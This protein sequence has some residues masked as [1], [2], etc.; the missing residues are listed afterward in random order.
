MAGDDTS[1][2]SMMAGN[3]K[4]LTIIMDGN[5]SVAKKS[6]DFIEVSITELK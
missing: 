1:L 3:D 5:D 6:D 2:T 4:R